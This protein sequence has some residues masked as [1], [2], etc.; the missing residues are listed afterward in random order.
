MKRILTLL[1]F[2]TIITTLAFA[3]QAIGSWH[4]LLSYHNVSKVEPAGELIYTIGNGGLFSYD[5]EDESVSTYCKENL[6]NDTNIKDIAYSK[7][8]KT[9]VIVYNNGNIDL[10][11]ND[12]EVYNLPDYMNKNMTQDKTINSISLDED[13]AYLSTAF[14][15]VVINLKRQEIA[16]SY[17]LNVG[18]NSCAINEGKIY[19]ASNNGLYVGHLDDNLLDSKNWK[20]EA[21]TVFSKIVVYDEKLIGNISGTGIFKINTDS[22]LSE[23]MISG[24]YTYLDKY[25]DKMMAG[26]GDVLALWD[27]PNQMYYMDMPINFFSLAYENGMYWA[28]CNYEGLRGMR[29][30]KD[31]REFAIEVSSITPNSPKRNDI[32]NMRLIGDKLFITGGGVSSYAAFERQ[33]LVMSMDNH[34]WNHFQDDDIWKTTGLNY[35]DII[36]IVEDPNDERRHYVSS[37]GQ[38]LYEFY[39]GKYA[40]R[41]TYD[42]STLESA[43]PDDPE[44][45]PAYVRIGGM[46]WDK[47]NNLWI[48]NSN[49]QN[50]IQVM[51]ADGTWKALSYSSLD[52]PTFLKECMFDRYGR[53]WS[54]SSLEFDY[55]VFCLDYNGTID[56]TTD[57]KHKFVS[58]FINQDGTQLSHKGMNC[59]VEDL[60]GVIWIGT[61]QGPIVLNNTSRFFESSYRCTQVKVPRNDGTNLADFL[62]ANDNI[63]S[64]AVD[65][66]N[67]KWLGTAGN[68]VYL[69]SEDG[70]ET[71]EH[72]TKE[73]SPLPDNTI[74]SLLV[75][76]TSGLVYI[77]TDKGLVAYQG[78]ATEGAD[79]YEASEVYAY[80][81][82]VQSGYTGVI[83]V[84]GLMRDSDVKIVNVAGEL[85]F[86]GTSV[87]GQFTWNG[88]NRSGK[89]VP[90]GVY[91]VL[92]SDQNAKEG[93]VTK[94]VMIR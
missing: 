88:C 54:I 58:N 21:L 74:T 33:G 30:N 12:S 64:I 80:P 39:D 56:N 67:R 57:D 42:N 6:L 13:N 47:S 61:A 23:N 17:I 14:G 90:S 60:N 85:V 89:R 69:V 1:F 48:V 38:G 45:K 24:H 37:F 40:N 84:T 51:K 8:N 65:G 41:F 53:L 25:G 5:K 27:N 20:R 28:P 2:S 35:K 63:T 26:N 3:Q 11:V 29:F 71:I 79:S 78:D 66:G 81:N 43:V 72:F 86:E 59:I 55:G 82:P 4:S 19:A 68:G 18:V 49:V 75:H 73:N 44:A 83:T 70:L 34:T 16:N 93:V 94:I 36:D 62:L 77:G 22:Y 31:N 10:L 76:P 7:P 92:A 32:Y 9:L 15:I 91:F 52:N 50:A 46:S 87:G